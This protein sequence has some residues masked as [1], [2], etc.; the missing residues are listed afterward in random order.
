MTPRLIPK[1]LVPKRL[2]LASLALL[3]VVPAAKAVPV[4]PRA[5][6]TTLALAYEGV[7]LVKV[8]DMRI[9]QRIG[10]EDYSATARLKSHGVLWLFKRINVTAT[11]AGRFDGAIPR[12]SAFDHTNADGEENRRVKVRWT[13]EDV[14]TAAA[15]AYN[16][17]GDP[18]PTPAQKLTAADPL[19]QLTRLALA[20]SDK[21]P[22]ATSARF[23]D[24]RQL[25]QVDFGAPS[26]RPA[27]AREQTLGLKNPIACTLA[28]NEVAGFDAGKPKNQGLTRPMRIEF[29]TAGQDGP[30]VVTAVRGKT[31]LGEA[32]VEITGLASTTVHRSLL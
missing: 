14:T 20:S 7:L 15:P 12:P 8:L 6:G 24:G 27:T 17:P 25:Y 2:I 21:G 13:A 29:A 16:G 5:A 11:A 4:T 32:R 3:A 22:C 26:P 9:E 1:R 10:G 31:P 23:F 28:Y 18:A 30:W 19:T